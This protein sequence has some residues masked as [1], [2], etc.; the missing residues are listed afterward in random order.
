MSPMDNCNVNALIPTRKSSTGV[1]LPPLKGHLRFVA[2]GLFYL[3]YSDSLISLG[4]GL[5]TR[6]LNRHGDFA[7]TQHITKSVDTEGQ[8]ACSTA[9]LWAGVD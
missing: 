9:G 2:S 8:F 5:I 6:R 7:S 1:L 4:G 3:S